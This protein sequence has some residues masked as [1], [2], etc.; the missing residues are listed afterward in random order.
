MRCATVSLLLVLL[1][2]TAALAGA[3]ART[4]S[5]LLE[6]VRLHPESFQANHAL[7]EYYVQ[8]H[9]LSAAIPYLK[10]ARLADLSNFENAYDLALGYLQNGLTAKRR[11][12]IN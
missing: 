5:D 11:E 8:H 2:P 12:W 7:G 3:A 9:R 6:Q 10:K 4:E 1:A